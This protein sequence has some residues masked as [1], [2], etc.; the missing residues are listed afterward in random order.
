M[1]DNW[2]AQKYIRDVLLFHVKRFEHLGNTE[3][4]VQERRSGIA[5]KE[6][7][8]IESAETKQKM[9]AV[10]SSYTLRA[11]MLVAS[12]APYMVFFHPGY[13]FSA[14]PAYFDGGWHGFSLGEHPPITYDELQSISLPGK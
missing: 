1:P 9:E 5:N 2:I 11:F 4:V 12:V 8:K 10:K 14:T 13:L 3:W 7:A 6:K